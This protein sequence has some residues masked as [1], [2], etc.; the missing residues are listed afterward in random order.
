MNVVGFDHL[1]LTVR[2]LAATCRFY[3]EGLGLRHERFGEGRHALRLGAQKINLHEAG[4]EFEPRAAHPV[5]GSADFCL[6][7][8]EALETVGAR[9]AALGHPVLLGPV[10]RTG[11]AGPIL[12]LYFRDPDGNLVEVARPLEQ[13]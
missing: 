9:M 1:V 5:P 2:D 6:L 3:V 8:E 13:G 4:R 10:R 12:S 7:T 11:A